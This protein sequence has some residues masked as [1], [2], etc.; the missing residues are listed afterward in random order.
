MK[1]VCLLKEHRWTKEDVF[2]LF[3]ST[4]IQEIMKKVQ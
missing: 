4:E 1:H 3:S 2:K